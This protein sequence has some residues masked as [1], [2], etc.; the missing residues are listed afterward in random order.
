MKTDEYYLR[1]TLLEAIHQYNLEVLQVQNFEL[2][3]DKEN[4]K[5]A[6]IDLQIKILE[7]MK[8][9]LRIEKLERELDVL[10]K[11]KS[12]SYV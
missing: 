3:D 9:K 1:K 8:T 2:P 6:E 5:L 12:D 11:I 7:T 10:S 4:L